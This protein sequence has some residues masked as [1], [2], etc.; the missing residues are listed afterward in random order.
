MSEGFCEVVVSAGVEALDAIG[1]IVESGQHEDGIVVAGRPDSSA[2]LESVHARQHHVQQHQTRLDLGGRRQRRIPVGNDRN[3]MTG[4]CQGPLDRGGD[5]MVIF[6]D[7]DV[8][9]HKGACW[10]QV[11]RKR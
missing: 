7:E 8:G 4:V 3:R 11:I 1:D 10:H 5:S 9:L 2:D 6:D